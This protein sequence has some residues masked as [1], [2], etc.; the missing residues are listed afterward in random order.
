MGFMKVQ[1]EPVFNGKLDT[2]DFVCQE[3]GYVIARG[4]ER[5]QLKDFISH[6]PRCGAFLYLHKIR[7]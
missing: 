4:I 1:N 6:C 3:C 2:P 5:N 7:Q